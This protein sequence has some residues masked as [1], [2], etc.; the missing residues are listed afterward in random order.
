MNFETSRTK[1]NLMAAFSGESMARNKYLF[2]ADKARKEG[3]DEVADLFEAMAKNE[4]VHGR[5]FYEKAVGI[6]SSNANLQEAIRGE[7][8]EWSSMYPDFAKQAREEG[9][10]D[11]AELFEGV[12]K[13]EKNHEYQFMATLAQL[14]SGGQQKPTAALTASAAPAAPAA[15]QAPKPV[16]AEGYRCMFCGAIYDKRPDVCGLCH[17]IGSFEQVTYQKRS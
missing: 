5:L 1:Q 4:G 10:D 9:Y 17:A 12:A 13:V 16:Q 6:G 2:F 15:Q 3:H 11:I 7:Y 8:G 14:Q